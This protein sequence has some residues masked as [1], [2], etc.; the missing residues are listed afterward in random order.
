MTGRCRSDVLSCPSSRSSAPGRTPPPSTTTSWRPTAHASG[1]RSSVRTAVIDAKRAVAA[2]ISPSSSTSPSTRSTRRGSRLVSSVTAECRTFG[3][4]LARV[5]APPGF[6]RTA[7]RVAACCRP[8]LCSRE[9]ADQSRGPSHNSSTSCRTGSPRHDRCRAGRFRPEWAPAS[10]GVRGRWAPS[11]PDIPGHPMIDRS[12]L[13]LA[14][15]ALLLIGATAVGP[16]VHAQDAPPTTAA[17]PGAPL[18]ERLDVLAAEIEAARERLAP[19]AAA[20]DVSEA[21]AWIA[22]SPR[23]RLA[24]RA[25]AEGLSE[26]E[27]KLWQQALEHEEAGAERV[28]GALSRAALATA[29]GDRLAEALRRVDTLRGDAPARSE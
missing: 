27:R 8:V 14:A 9:N 4:R 18:E 15:A 24:E 26:A 2:S 22:A 25:A 7:G 20:V 6:D 12:F 21:E 19:L 17:A 29:A 16:A 28:R 3:L 13:P 5:P 23:D 1:G 11:P 10:T